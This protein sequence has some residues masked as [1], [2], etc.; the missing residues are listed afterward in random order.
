MK[1][2]F[3][4]LSPDGQFLLFRAGHRV[5][6]VFMHPVCRTVLRQRAD[7]CRRPERPPCGTLFSLYGLLPL[8]LFSAVLN[9]LFNHEGATILTYL[10]DG[11]P[12]TLESMLYGVSAAAM[13]VTVILWF[14]CYNSVMTSD[15]FLY[16]FGRVIPALSLL[17]P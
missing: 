12:L 11:N 6:H 15:K 2:A 1:D 14:S 16:L 4:R 5:F 17:F 3:F 10:P 7:V 9:P 13:M 8:L